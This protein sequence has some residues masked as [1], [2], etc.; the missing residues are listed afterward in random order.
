MARRERLFRTTL[1]VTLVIIVSKLCGF[2]RDM[3]TANYFGTGIESDAYTAAYSMFYL[4][5]LLFN[6]CI[7][8]TLV[9]LF[10]QAEKDGGP[11]AAN[12][13]GS[14]SFNLFALAA[15]V[16]AAIMYVFAGPLVRLV[17]SGF[18]PEKLE[19]TA[20]LTRIMMLSLVFNVTSIV[21]ST[22][23]NAREKFMAAQLTGF[24]L[25]L[26]VIVAAVCF[27]G[28]YGIQALAWGVFVSGV[29]QVLIQLPFFFG[30][31]KYSAY[32]D[33]ADPRFRQ[34]LTLAVPAMLSMAVSELN[35]MIDHW[36]ASG[37]GDGAMTALNYAYKLITFIS[38]ILV[39]PLTTVIFSKLSKLVANRDTKGI[40]AVIRRCMETI[41]LVL[42]PIILICA[43]LRV[44]VIRFAYGSGRF[45]DRSIQMTSGAFLFYVIGV[46][47]FGLRDL[48]NRA[49]HAM[50]DTRTP[51][52][53]GWSGGGAERDFE[54]HP[55]GA[56]GGQRP[57]PGHHAGGGHG[58][59]GASAQPVPAAGGPGAEAHGAGSDKSAGGRRGMRPGVLDN[60]PSHGAR[61]GQNRGFLPPGGDFSGV[62]GLL[63]AGG[64]AFAGTAAG[65]DFPGDSGQT[66]G[67]QILEIRGFPIEKIWKQQKEA[68]LWNIIRRKQCA[69][70][71][72]IG[73]KTVS[74]G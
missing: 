71:R 66:E 35:H 28:R 19:L 73:P 47:T 56:D 38:G 20:Q 67:R 32:I 7:T 52:R 60:G 31:F 64:T 53:V 63:R 23:L 40:A 24:P 46:L 17:Y 74:P 5:V 45:D 68:T 72:A 36:L 34:L 49:F 51:F 29:L 37:L 55:S 16:I 21:M 61:G 69:C 65:G 30:W 43:V 54:L 42:V 27:S 22:L 39:V 26:A 4:P 62:P 44:D 8:S 57:C 70:R 33:L 50:K 11:R 1:T 14:N 3:I 48:L 25:S 10:V 12:R 13:F 2:A 15:L 59:G 9:P 58:H 41:S 18:S 6:S